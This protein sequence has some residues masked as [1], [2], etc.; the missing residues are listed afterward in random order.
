M[1]RRFLLWFS[2]ALL[3]GSAML[4]AIASDKVSVV[5]GVY[6]FSPFVH[7]DKANGL[8]S[9]ATVE[10]VEALNQL[11]ANYNFITTLNVAYLM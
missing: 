5:V 3:S 10:L 8:I 2:L 9:G 1:T 11:Q 4:P 7:E 6:P